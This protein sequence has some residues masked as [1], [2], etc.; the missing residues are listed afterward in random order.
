[1]LNSD[2]SISVGADTSIASAC[3]VTE[4]N[5]QD[6]LI[7]TMVLIFF[8]QLAQHPFYIKVIICLP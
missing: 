3:S 7:P 4:V 6:H 5:T 8:Q 2:H 1:M